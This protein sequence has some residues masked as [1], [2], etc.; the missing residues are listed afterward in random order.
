M[1]NLRE[2]WLPDDCLTTTAWK[3]QRCR[4]PNL[5]L[6]IKSWLCSKWPLNKLT[7]TGLWVGPQKTKNSQLIFVTSK[8]LTSE[9]TPLVSWE[10]SKQARKA[11][12][13]FIWA[14]KLLGYIRLTRKLVITCLFFVICVCL[15]IELCM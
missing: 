5:L 8:K 7:I 3:F 15:W 1:I 6:P 14:Y 2:L 4:L 13:L 11:A 12:T 10:A 9:R